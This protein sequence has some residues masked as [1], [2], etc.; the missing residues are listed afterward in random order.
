MSFLNIHIRKQALPMLL[1]LFI[2]LEVP[3]SDIRVRHIFGHGYDAPIL[4]TNGKTYKN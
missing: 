2:F 4:Q 1:G 3:V